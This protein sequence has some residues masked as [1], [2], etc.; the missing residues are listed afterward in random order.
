MEDLRN[1]I[2]SIR[3]I[4]Q[5]N[6]IVDSG[7]WRNNDEIIRMLLAKYNQLEKGAGR[8]G[9][10][11][12]WKAVTDLPSTSGSTSQNGDNDSLLVTECDGKKAR[13]CCIQQ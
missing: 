13:K 4:S 6:N 11:D 10:E 2:T 12:F 9:N 5:W 7:I 3:N 8:L 1:A